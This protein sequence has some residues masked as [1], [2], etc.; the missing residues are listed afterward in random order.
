M[1][2]LEKL[3]PGDYIRRIITGTIFRV[4]NPEEYRFLEED[5]EH[6]RVEVEDRSPQPLDFWLNVRLGDAGNLECSASHTFGGAA[7]A[8][9]ASDLLARIHIQT[10]V[11]HFDVE[12][13][14]E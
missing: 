12:P 2:N 11:G 13:S 1:L 14:D 10:T 7:V 5:Y 8:A 3:S 9:S 4:D 6:V